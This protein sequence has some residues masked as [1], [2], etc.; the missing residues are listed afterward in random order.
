MPCEMLKRFNRMGAIIA[1][2]GA[3]LLIS[4]CYGPGIAQNGPTAAVARITPPQV[5]PITAIAQI[6]DQRIEL[7]VAAKPRQQE[8]GLMYRKFLPLNQGMLFPFQPARPVQFWMKNC[9]LT[10]DMIFLR[11]KTVVAI[12]V[13]AVP[14][15]ADPCPLYG[16]NEPVD[17]V[18]ELRGG[19]AAQLGVKVG[20]VIDVQPLHAAPSVTESK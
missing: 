17:Q 6:A 12:A 13:N 14:C 18:I 16:P 15:T 4:S 20:S 11:Q 2:A 3:G 7:E 19:R 9:F 10:L 5:L 1:I 8:L